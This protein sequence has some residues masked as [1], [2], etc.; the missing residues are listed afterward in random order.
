MH[1]KWNVPGLA[2]FDLAFLVGR[3]ILAGGGRGEGVE[4]AAVVADFLLRLGRLACACRRMPLSTLSV[5]AFRLRLRLMSA[6]NE[7]GRG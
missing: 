7:S 2:G 6:I 4:G 5:N 1:T 3:G